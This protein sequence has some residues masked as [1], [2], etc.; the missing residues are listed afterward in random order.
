[1]DLVFPMDVGNQCTTFHTH[2][3]REEHL[4]CCTKH[5]E[6]TDGTYRSHVMQRASIYHRLAQRRSNNQSKRELVF[7]RVDR[8]PVEV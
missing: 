1:M 5:E 8:G 6:T 3:N 4:S 2:T 7:V